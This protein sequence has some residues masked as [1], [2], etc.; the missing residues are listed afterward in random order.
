MLNKHFTW[1]W[2]HSWIIFIALFFWTRSWW[3][4]ALPIAVGSS[5]FIKVKRHV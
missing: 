1:I 4:I 2:I 5:A 3:M